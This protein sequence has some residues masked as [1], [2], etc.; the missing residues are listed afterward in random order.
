MTDPGMMPALDREVPG[1]GRVLRTPDDCFEGIV[2]YPWE[3]HY[4]QLSSGLHMAYIDV[5]P[6]DA[7]ETILLLHGEP[8]WGY[9]YRTM[10]P[11]LVAAGHRVIVPDLI[12]FGRSDKPV[13]SCT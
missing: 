1:I 8:M 11:T 2:D 3:P 5:G 7:T 9:L 4:V 10:V 13:D 12:G 6:A